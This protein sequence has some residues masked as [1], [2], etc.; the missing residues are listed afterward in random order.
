MFLRRGEKRPLVNL[1]YS[2]AFLPGL[3]VS[4]IAS[5]QIA[6]RPICHYKTDDFA[7]FLPFFRLEVFGILRPFGK[8]VDFCCFSMFLTD[9]FIPSNTLNK[10]RYFHRGMLPLIH[11]TGTQDPL[12]NP[13]YYEDMLDASSALQEMIQKLIDR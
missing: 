3:S 2:P 9:S 1:I 4:V 11:T 6:R 5:T 12:Q 13:T 10:C 8:A 7:F